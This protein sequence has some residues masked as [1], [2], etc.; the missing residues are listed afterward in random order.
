MYEKIRQ[1][2]LEKF[3]YWESDICDDDV[4]DLPKHILK[5]VLEQSDSFKLYRYMPAEYFSIRN[6]E[7]QTIHLSPNGVMNDVFEGLP[8]TVDDVAYHQ[9]KKLSD[10]AYMVCLTE[11]NDNLLMWSHYAKNHEGLCVEYDIKWLKDDPHK[12]L[13]H[14]FPIIYRKSRHYIRD[15]TSLIDS[16]S[17]L[18]RAVR[19]E[20]DYCGD[21]CLDDILPMFLSKSMEWEYEKEWRILYTLKQMYDINSHALY[22]CNLKFPC[23]SAVYVGCRI[24]PEIRKNIVEIC[25]RNSTNI[26]PI[27]VYQA[28]LAKAK[29]EIIFDRI[30]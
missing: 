15:I 18:T 20:T 17:E 3:E 24:H 1:E 8:E 10:L 27:P 28:K 5:E 23:I 2:L 11:R 22:G 21:E 16:H 30:Y 12:I 29:Y 26:S 14:L 13:E 4:T 9:L 6:I 25:E 7:T 19:D